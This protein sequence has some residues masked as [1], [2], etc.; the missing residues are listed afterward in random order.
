MLKNDDESL[1][2]VDVHVLDKKTKTPRKKQKNFKLKNTK[3]QMSAFSLPRGQLVPLPPVSY[4]TTHITFKVEWLKDPNLRSQLHMDTGNDDFSITNSA[5]QPSE[6]QTYPCYCGIIILTD[7]QVHQQS[8]S[9]YSPA[10]FV[11]S[12]YGRQQKTSSNFV[13]TWDFLLKFAFLVNVYGVFPK[14]SF[15]DSMDLA[16]NPQQLGSVLEVIFYK[17]GKLF[18]P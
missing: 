9:M 4:A 11:M 17:C 14:I 16:F 13:F 8:C 2:V 12:K 5:R 15:I 6:M 1:D 10:R 7:T 18:A 3:Y